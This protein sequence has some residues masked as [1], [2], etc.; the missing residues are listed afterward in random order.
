VIVVQ[1][2]RKDKDHKFHSDRLSPNIRAEKSCIVLIR[3]SRAWCTSCPMD[4][5]HGVSSRRKEHLSTSF[6]PCLEGLLVV[7]DE[8]AESL[9][10]FKSSPSVLS[11]DCRLTFS[12]WWVGLGGVVG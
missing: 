11:G 3:S 9:N 10:G 8:L 7:G 2:S 4:D 6:A 1:W 12:S 5:T